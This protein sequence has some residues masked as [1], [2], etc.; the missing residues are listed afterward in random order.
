MQG[1]S[2]AA[3][4]GENHGRLLDVRQSSDAHQMML[5]PQRWPRPTTTRLQPHPRRLPLTRQQRR[6]QQQPQQ[7]HLEQ[8]RCVGTGFRVMDKTGEFEAL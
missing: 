5:Q 6:R 2:P 1:R 8:M 3:S 7:R 4:L